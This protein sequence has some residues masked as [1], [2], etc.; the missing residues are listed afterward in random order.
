MII[1]ATIKDAALATGLLL[2]TVSKFING[3]NVWIKT[4]VYAFHRCSA[5]ATNQRG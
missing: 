4:K 2:A 3:G 1:A 5:S